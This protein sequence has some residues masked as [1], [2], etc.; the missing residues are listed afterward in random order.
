MLTSKN[1]SDIVAFTRA[2]A[3]WRFS[4]GGVLVQESANVPRL[5]YD[6]AALAA[7]GLLVEEARTNLCPVSVPG[8][9]GGGWGLSGG[10]T[11]TPN[12]ALGP[13]GQMTMT[14]W[15]RTATTS[16]ALSKNPGNVGASAAFCASVFVRA[17]T[18]GGYA[19]LRIQGTYPTRADVNISLAD[20]STRIVASA[21][22]TNVVA[23]SVNCGNGLWRV[24]IAGTTDASGTILALLSC[25]DSPNAQVDFTLGTADCDCYFDGF[26]M[27]AGLF[28][29]SY[30]PTTTAQVTRAADNAII[31]DLSKIGFNASEGTI[32][33]DA[34]CYAANAVQNGGNSP[35]LAVLYSSS[36][37]GENIALYRGSG[38]NQAS[39]QVSTGGQGFPVTGPVIANGSKF[40][41]AFAYKAGDSAL[42]LNGAA[43][44]T[45]AQ[46]TLPSGLDRMVIGSTGTAGYWGAWIRQARYFPRRMTNAE[47]QTLTT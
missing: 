19:V 21:N 15:Q 44:N 30:I 28:P 22:M 31:T 16:S 36:N 8:S 41:L 47:L 9:A 5:S 10:S 7:R 24:W 35:R 46:A 6:P 12:A 20:G 32:F 1:F 4:S 43:V 25:V 34:E 45:L 37:G 29:T 14:K 38:T 18:S 23:G 39:A 17:G 3:A 11:V 13:T 40:K 26:Q 42:C 2:S 27:E 33:F